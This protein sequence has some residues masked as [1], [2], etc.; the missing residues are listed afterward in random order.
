V[1]LFGRVR[2]EGRLIEVLSGRTLDQ[3]LEKRLFAP[4]GMDDYALHVSPRKAALWLTTLGTRR[5]RLLSV[6]RR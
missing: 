1:E 3:F 4:L 2:H 6:N 5:P